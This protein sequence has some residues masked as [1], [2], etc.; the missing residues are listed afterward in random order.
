MKKL[1][2][3][4]VFAAFCSH[5]VGQGNMDP[6]SSAFSNGTPIA[7]MKTLDQIEPRVPIK[8]LPRL[9]NR[10]G[11]YYL[12]GSLTSAVAGIVIDCD[13]V[14]LDLGGFAVEGISMP[15]SGGIFVSNSHHNITIQNGVVRGWGARGVCA[16]TAHESKVVGVTAF[17]NGIDGIH[18]G[19]NGL[20]QDCGSFKNGNRGIVA[21]QAATIRNC[22]ARDNASSGIELGA[23]G[24][25][26]GCV[27]GNNGGSGIY[28]TWYCNVKDCI[29][30]ANDS[31]GIVVDKNCKVTDNSSGNNINGYG[32]HIR[33]TGNRIVGNNL[34]DN[35]YG[36][37]TE[38]AATNNLIVRNTATGN[39][40][41]NYNI[42]ENNA[43]GTPQTIHGQLDMSIGAWANFG[44]DRKP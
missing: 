1:L 32:L 23:G 19:Q 11:S 25:V 31:H 37:Y 26:I 39:V 14:T 8:A 42:G 41:A 3:V 5:A 35:K 20:I 12:T 27:S 4:V 2:L 7:V 33:N 10:P 17:T 30:T 13:D 44:L 15:P 18:L 34:T 16:G 40:S 43:Y 6:P 29:V 36:I 22:K 38:T 28:A 21:N 24:R 9:I